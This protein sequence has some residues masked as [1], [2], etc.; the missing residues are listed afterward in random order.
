MDIWQIIGILCDRT[1]MPMIKM[2]FDLLAK[3]FLARVEGWHVAHT[4]KTG[5]PYIEY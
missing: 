4:T 5:L 3:A 2:L 1:C